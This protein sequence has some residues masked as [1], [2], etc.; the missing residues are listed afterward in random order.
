MSIAIYS[1]SIPDTGPTPAPEIL[2]EVI[3]G[4]EWAGF[5]VEVI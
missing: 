1:S 5:S 2:D 3:K 4:L